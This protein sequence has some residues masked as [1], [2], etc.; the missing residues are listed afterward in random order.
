[1][2]KH[3]NKKD[4]KDTAKV[5]SL[6][7]MIELQDQVYFLK[8]LDEMHEFQPFLL[9]VLIGYQYDLTPLQHE[10]VIKIFA[11]I[12]EYFG[13]HENLRKK[14][15]RESDLKQIVAGSLH[16]LQSYDKETS[17]D[18]KNAAFNED[19]ARIN[20]TKLYLAIFYLINS[21]KE[22]DNMG[23]IERTYLAMGLKHII[24]CI[25]AL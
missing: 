21:D 16:T 23:V 17:T 18:G 19:M 11:L 9:S 1:M 25:E 15:I 20:A 8:V 10:K 2:A 3:I 6:I 22:F 24:E 5:A 12:W 14:Q 13:D 4:L 7:R